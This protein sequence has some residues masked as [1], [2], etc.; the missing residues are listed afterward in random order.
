MGILAGIYAL[1]GI[2]GTAYL[3]G[4]GIGRIFKREASNEE[5]CNMFSEEQRRREE[6]KRKYKELHRGKPAI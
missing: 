5:F 4:S 3:A 1:L 2:G 6:N